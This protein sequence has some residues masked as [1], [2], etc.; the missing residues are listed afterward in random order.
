VEIVTESSKPARAGRVSPKAVVS[1][2][3]ASPGVC[4]ALS[5]DQI[6]QVVRSVSSE[7]VALIAG[8]GKL[9]GALALKSGALGDPRLCKSLLLGLSILAC[10]PADGSYIRV[11][12][13]ARISSA[14]PTNVHR[15]VATLVA[16]GLAERH[17]RTHEYGSS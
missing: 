14:S 17:P 7:A 11:V 10:F 12:E 16:A 6:N 9:R 15:Y 3:R 2:S 13:I 1:E 8:F 5:P 4:I